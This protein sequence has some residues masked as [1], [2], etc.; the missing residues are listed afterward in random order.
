MSTSFI[1]NSQ[2]PILFFVSPHT[3]PERKHYFVASGLEIEG[4]SFFE[5]CSLRVDLQSGLRTFS[6]FDFHFR[7]WLPVPFKAIF[8]GEEGLWGLRKKRGVPH[9]GYDLS[10]GK[11]GFPVRWVIS[12]KN[13]KLSYRNGWPLIRRGIPDLP[14]F[15]QGFRPEKCQLPVL[16]AKNRSK[17]GNW[18]KWSKV[19]SKER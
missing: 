13:R 7:L 2:N 11:V 19:C 3:P 12:G 6:G 1:K 17:T 5:S 8:K 16:S 10:P 18:P 9:I 4:H 14:R 15:G